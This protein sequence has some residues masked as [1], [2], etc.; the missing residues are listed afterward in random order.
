ME[1]DSKFPSST[2]SPGHQASD[3]A[4]AAGGVGGDWLIRVLGWAS[5]GT[6]VPLLLAPGGF[7]RALGVGDGP[8]ERAAAAVAGVRQVAVGAGL[9]RWPSPVWLWARVGGDVMDLAWLGCVLKRSNNYDKRRTAAV[10][11]ALAGIT[12]A[13]VY[14][15]TTRSPRRAEVRLTA[16]VTVVTPAMQAYD[17]WRRLEILPSFM[18]HLD[19]VSLTGPVT[20]HWRAS[21]PFGRT[22]EWDAD[23]TGDVAGECLA[24]RS[25][26]NPAIY[27]EGD[28]RF[29]PAPGGRGTEVHVTLRYS[30]SAARLAAASARYFGKYPSLH[31]DDDLRRFKQLAETGEVVMSE[32]ALAGKRA[33]RG[34]SQHPARP[35]SPDELMEAR[36]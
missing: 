4:A 11:V 1:P 5:A 18:A 23:I 14:A 13:D 2:P 22:V 29:T 17:L 9:L 33:R 30:I 19:E 20:S 8:R 34:F 25:L 28:V 24:W 35:L 31:L 10:M 32:G 26:D 6:G 36:S 21:A 15:A 7:S 27:S 12:G 16:S 3:Q